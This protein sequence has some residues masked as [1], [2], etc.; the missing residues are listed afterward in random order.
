MIG[1]I[2]LSLLMFMLLLVGGAI[3]L[4][5]TGFG[6]LVYVI[7]TNAEVARY[8]GVDIAK[9]KSILFLASGLISAL[10]GL[11]YAARLASVRGD[12]AFGFELDIITMVLLGGISIFGGKGSML[13]MALT[14]I[15]GHI[16]TALIGILLITSVLGPN[17]YEM[18]RSGGK[19]S[20]V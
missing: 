20:K 3:I 11:F 2:P 10:A 14:N 12:A 7:G 13:G 4:H 16:Q 1:P 15:T 19:A 9:V 6:R 8:S 17:L 18:F 5:R